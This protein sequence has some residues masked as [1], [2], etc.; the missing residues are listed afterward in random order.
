MVRAFGNLASTISKL[1]EAICFFF[2]TQLSALL[3]GCLSGG[4]QEGKRWFGHE[5]HGC[6]L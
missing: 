4:S 1:V 5:E 2:F 3:H 6:D